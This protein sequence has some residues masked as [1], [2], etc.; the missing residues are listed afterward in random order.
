MGGCSK[1]QHPRSHWPHSP[2]PL[3][4]RRKGSRVQRL[5]KMRILNPGGSVKD[6]IGY[7]MVLEAEKQGRIKP[8][9]TLIEP[10]SGN[11]GIGIALAGA[12][13]GYR[14]IITMPKKMSWRCKTSRARG[15]RRGNHSHAD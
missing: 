2:C 5:R 1:E 10:T 11:T 9:D 15:P 6:R 12:V 8:G 7:N 3:E 13:K 14:V 4:S